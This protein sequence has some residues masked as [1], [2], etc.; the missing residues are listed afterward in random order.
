MWGL[1]YRRAAGASSLP[2]LAAATIRQGS[3]NPSSTL[4]PTPDLTTTLDEAVVLSIVAARAANAL[5]IGPGRGFA[6]RLSSATSTLQGMG[7]GLADQAGGTAGTTLA[8]PTW[9]RTGS[10]GQWAW[11]TVAFR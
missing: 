2:R 7:L 9:S 10:A 3:A 1:H 11:A 6:L 8:S 5:A 4:T